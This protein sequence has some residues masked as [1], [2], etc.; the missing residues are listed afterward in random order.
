M[1]ADHRQTPNHHHHHSYST[2]DREEVWILKHIPLRL[3][4][5][6]SPEPAQASPSGEGYDD[7]D[8]PVHNAVEYSACYGSPT[9]AVETVAEIPR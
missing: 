1:M 7:G 3:Q 2:A 4:E 8:A 5:V 6:A 9:V